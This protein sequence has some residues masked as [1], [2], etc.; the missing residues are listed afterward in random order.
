MSTTLNDSILSIVASKMDDFKLFAE[1]FGRSRFLVYKSEVHAPGENDFAYDKE[2]AE[3]E[4]IADAFRCEIIQ[5]DQKFTLFFHMDERNPGGF[6][7]IVDAGMPAPLA[8]GDHGTSHNP[9][10]TTYAS[11]TPKSRWNEPV[12]EYAKPETGVINEIRTMLQT[13][14]HGFFT[15]TVKDSKAEILKA[16]KQQVASRLKSVTG[17]NS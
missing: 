16:M 17:G 6:L 12:P 7:E 15:D 11:S 3:M 2:D 13:L 4:A 5:E 14:F 8:G 1:N 10:G 9:D